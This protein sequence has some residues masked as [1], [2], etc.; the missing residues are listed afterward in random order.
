MEVNFE[1]TANPISLD[2][3]RTFSLV[4]LQ[5]GDYLAISVKDTG[6]GI[7]ASIRDRIFDPFFT[8]KD[9]GQGT[10]LGLSTS[11]G[12]VR[13]HR[14]AVDVTSSVGGGTTVRVIFP[15]SPSKAETQPTLDA[16]SAG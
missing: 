2:K 11:L 9:R 7:P 13:S 12:I 15:L 14:G 8:T 5:P 6:T 1:I 16:T 10:G 4:T 3:E